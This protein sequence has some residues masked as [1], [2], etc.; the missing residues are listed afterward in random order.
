MITILSYIFWPKYYYLN[1][2]N[3][4]FESAINNGANLRL[5][6]ISFFKHRKKSNENI[7]LFKKNELWNEPTKSSDLTI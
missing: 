7:L 1:C 3:R 2:Q 4:Y 6:Y 5:Q